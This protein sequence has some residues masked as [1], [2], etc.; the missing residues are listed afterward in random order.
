MESDIIVFD[1]FDMTV[2][3]E[4]LQ[5]VLDRLSSGNTRIQIW[6]IQLKM[7]TFRVSY[8]LRVM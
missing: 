3:R 8:I 2:N 7:H 1:V 5:Y 6:Y 4:V